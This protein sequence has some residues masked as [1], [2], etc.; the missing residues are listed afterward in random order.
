MGYFQST[1]NMQSKLSSLI[2]IT[3]LFW[4]FMSCQ[5][6][7]A[8]DASAFLHDALKQ[9]RQFSTETL[10]S[11]AENYRKMIEN[12]DPVAI[13]EDIPGNPVKIGKGIGIIPYSPEVVWQVLNDYDNYKDFMPFTEES[14]VDP[15]RSGGDVVYFYSKLSFPLISD[16]YYS[17]KITNETNVGKQLGTFFTSWELDIEKE[18]NLYLNSGSWKLVPYDDDGQKTL[19]FYTVLTDPGGNIP[20]FLKNKS[21]KMAIPSVFEAISERAHEGLSAGIYSIPLPGD[22]ID[23]IIR[24][25]VWQTRNLDQSFL[26]HFSSHEKRAIEEGK[27]IISMKDI[28]GSMVKMGQATALIDMPPTRLLKILTE[29]DR[30][31]ELM[32]HVS[33]STVDKKRSKG[34]VTFLSYRLHFRIYPYITD[35]YFTLKLVQDEVLKGSATYFIYWE[36]D[37]TKPSNINRSCGSWKIVPYGKRQSKSLVFY[38]V[39]ADPGGISPWFWRNISAKSAI[40]DIYNAIKK[41]ANT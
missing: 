29:Y 40:Y 30:Y 5:I 1:G 28:E 9:S 17:I 20:N 13:L 35:R 6:I 4:L 33:K 32:P 22:K 10:T 15:D 7:Y 41:R 21:T 24:D 26:D 36:L 34:N 37:S 12:G 11:L 25:R 38:T 8:Q 23:R 16:R 14:Q 31:D 18:T 19:A 3:T 39:F 27:V 2:K